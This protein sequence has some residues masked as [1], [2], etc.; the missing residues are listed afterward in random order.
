MSYDKINIILITFREIVKKLL[1]E[2]KAKRK[3]L[4]YKKKSSGI[5]LNKNCKL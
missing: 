4:L 5:P 2:L 3:N 1:T